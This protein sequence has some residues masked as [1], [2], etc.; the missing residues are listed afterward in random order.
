MREKMLSPKEIRAAADAYSG[1][2]MPE[3]ARRLRKVGMYFSRYI[4]EP[5]KAGERLDDTLKARLH[6]DIN[7]ARAALDE[8]M[9]EALFEVQGNRIKSAFFGTGALMSLAVS[10]TTFA[11][12][13][14]AGFAQRN[15]LGILNEYPAIGVAAGVTI[16]IIGIAST[17]G[18]AIHYGKAK[19]ISHEIDEAI[20]ILN[21]AMDIAFGWVKNPAE[22]KKD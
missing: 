16:S 10:I 4:P 8:E 13:V 14:S 21:S 22:S 11:N 1:T 15:G 12:T 7:E 9:P 20:K 2:A 17:G 19:E 6:R 5:H 18:A 3:T